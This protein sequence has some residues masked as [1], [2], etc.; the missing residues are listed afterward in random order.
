MSFD[1]TF[2]CSAVVV[3]V[4]CT[5]MTPKLFDYFPFQIDAMRYLCVNFRCFWT[6]CGGDSLSALISLQSFW[7]SASVRSLAICGAGDCWVILGLEFLLLGA[8]FHDSISFWIPL[9][10]I[11]CTS[12]IN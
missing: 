11:C 4:S 5:S 2:A 6:S 1:G 9:R 12:F 8:D 7:R 10:I 3:Q